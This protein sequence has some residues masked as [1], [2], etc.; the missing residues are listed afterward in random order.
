[1]IYTDDK[2]ELREAILRSSHRLAAVELQNRGLESA[3]HAIHHGQRV[4]RGAEQQRLQEEQARRVHQMHGRLAARLSEE[5]I[6]HELSRDL[7]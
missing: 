1:M 6:E 2:K 3:S 4:S 5:G 7:G